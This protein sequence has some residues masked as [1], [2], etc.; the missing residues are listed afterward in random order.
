MT[1]TPTKK[2]DKLNKELGKMTYTD[3]YNLLY[4]K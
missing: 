2:L 3:I 4:N 1:P